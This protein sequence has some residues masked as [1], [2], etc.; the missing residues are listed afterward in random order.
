MK[1]QK[2]AYY[3]QAWHAVWSDAQLFPERIEAWAN[4]P[5][6]PALYEKHRGQFILNQGQFKDD[7]GE[8]T[9]DEAD[10]VA[11]VLKAYGSKT[12]QWLSD[13]THMESP[14]VEARAGV[15]DG[16]RSNIEIPLGA[17]AE[18][19]GALATAVR[20]Y[21]RD[22][23]PRRM[24]LQIAATA[25]RNGLTLLTRNA[26]DFAGLEQALEIIELG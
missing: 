8:L 13:L 15:P 9:N 12:S 1:L 5:V 19:Y 14:W 22:P 3:S 23:R 11:R 6:V 18:Y 16:E 7:P 17:M 2:L 10:S 26:A 25:A 20:V 4:G 21:G 24:D